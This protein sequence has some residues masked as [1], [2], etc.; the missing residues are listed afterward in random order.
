M[1]SSSDESP[2]KKRLR[3]DDDLYLIGNINHQILG[4]KLPSY[5]QV[6]S[7][8]FY[9][10][11]IAHMNKSDSAKLVA[12]EVEIFYKKAGIPTAKPCNSAA[13]IERLVDEYKKLQKSALRSG[14]SQI[15]NEKS[16]IDKLDD[17]FDMS[18]RDAMS[19]IKDQKV[20]DFLNSQRQKGRIGCLLGVAKNEQLREEKRE[21]R[22]Q[23]EEARKVKALND[24]MRN[25]IFSINLFRKKLI[26]V[27]WSHNIVSDSVQLASSSNSSANA[28]ATSGS[29]FEMPSTFAL[30]EKKKFMLSDRL[31]ACLDKYKVSYRAAM[32][33]ITAVATS[34][35]INID[36]YI[37]NCYSLHQAREKYRSILATSK[38]TD[39]HVI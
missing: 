6:L 20:I 26:G 12:E 7:V 13:K 36:N 24:S 18:H 32:H 17:L 5:R 30:K 22:K 4:A 14:P 19:M 25:G 21:L 10:T 38:Q 9:N 3:K 37:I 33:I 11:R 39:F 2:Q 34:F 15:Q 23:Q 31:L 16:F 35:D 1:D 8:F 28:T 29:D 27:K